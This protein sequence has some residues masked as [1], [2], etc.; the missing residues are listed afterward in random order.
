MRMLLLAAV[1]AAF[2]GTASAQASGV[3]VLLE[4]DINVEDHE[5]AV[6][7]YASY[8]DLLADNQAA[9]TF[10]PHSRSGTPTT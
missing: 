7:D 2:F 3:H 1:G 10:S 4:T 9:T 5:L 6:I 8:A